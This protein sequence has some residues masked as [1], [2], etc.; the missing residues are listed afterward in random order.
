[1]M[2]CE[3]DAFVICNFF[4]FQHDDIVCKNEAN[5]ETMTSLARLYKLASKRYLNNVIR[6]R[7]SYRDKSEMNLTKDCNITKS[8]Y[9]II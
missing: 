1:M 9:F 6:F 3:E 8:I 2:F 5:E 7:K 4:E